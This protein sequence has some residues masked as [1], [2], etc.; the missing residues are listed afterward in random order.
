MRVR[1]VAYLMPRSH[2]G[3]RFL[4][5]ALHRFACQEERA[6]DVQFIQHVEYLLR[7]FR[8]AVVERQRHFLFVRLRT[9]DDVP[10]DLKAARIHPLVYA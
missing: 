8:W 9:A 6:F 2:D 4:H 3:L 7:V 5:M 1:V 10:R